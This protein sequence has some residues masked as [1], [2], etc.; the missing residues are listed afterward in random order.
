MNQMRMEM[1]GI[2]RQDKVMI[3]NYLEIMNRSLAERTKK[4]KVKQAINDILSL[5]RSRKKRIRLQKEEQKKKKKT[6]LITKSKKI[7][8][9][10]IFKNLK[11]FKKIQKFFKKL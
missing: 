2:L 4:I 10:K 6:N 8:I 1:K 7:K 11:N 9:R 5:K 3:K